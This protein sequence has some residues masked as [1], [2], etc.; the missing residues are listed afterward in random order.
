MTS[1]NSAPNLGAAAARLGAGFPLGP[2]FFILCVGG[3]TDARSCRPGK[4]STP[5]P[6]L[7]TV[8]CEVSTSRPR[9]TSARRASRFKSYRKLAWHASAVIAVFASANA[10]R[11]ELTDR[12]ALLTCRPSSVSLVL[13]S[14]MITAILVDDADKDDAEGDEADDV[15]AVFPYLLQRIH[16]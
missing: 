8:E 15:D 11:N 3:P 9:D 12:W 4:L 7:N 2:Q 14:A 5:W 13:S 6:A 1:R 16:P 10:V